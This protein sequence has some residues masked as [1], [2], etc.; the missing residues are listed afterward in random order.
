MFSCYRAHYLFTII[1]IFLLGL[2]IHS[3]LMSDET[4]SRQVL[5][6]EVMLQQTRVATVLPYYLTWMERW[7]DIA[8][9]ATASIDDVHRVWSG[10]GYYSRAT[11][12]HQAARKV[13]P[14]IS[15]PVSE[16]LAY[17]G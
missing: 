11:R 9:L 2:V 5:V 13:S 15:F 8:T 3:I 7:P 12:L 6:S 4:P 16:H 17:L 14:R 1:I 10:L